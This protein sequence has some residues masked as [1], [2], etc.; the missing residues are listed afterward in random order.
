MQ[1]AIIINLTKFFFQFLFSKESAILNGA[2][3][4][5]VFFCSTRRM[6]S[7]YEMPIVPGAANQLTAPF[8]SSSKKKERSLQNEANPHTEKEE[9]ESRKKT[10]A[11][12]TTTRGKWTVGRVTRHLCHQNIV[13]RRFIAN[14]YCYCF[15]ATVLKDTEKYA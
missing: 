9:E 8:A 12:T 15:V 11:I 1:K 13:T 7:I 10:S 2:T 14:N 4:I 6:I 5:C 3:I